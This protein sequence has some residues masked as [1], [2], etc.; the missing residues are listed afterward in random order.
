MKYIKKTL[1]LILLITLAFSYNNI[2]SS[3]VTPE[4]GTEIHGEYNH[5][6]ISYNGKKEFIEP[7]NFNDIQPDKSGDY[8]VWSREINGEGQIFRYHI[9][10]KTTLQLTHTSTNLK[11]KVDTFGR[12]VWEKWVKTGWQIYYFDGLKVN[13]LTNGQTA[14]NPD[15]EDNKIVYGLRNKNETFWSAQSYDTATQTTTELGRGEK[16]KHPKLVGNQVV[17]YLGELVKIDNNTKPTL[18]LE[19]EEIIELVIEDESKKEEQVSSTTEEV[20]ESTQ[21]NVIKEEDKPAT[22]TVEIIEAEIETLTELIQTETQESSS[23]DPLKE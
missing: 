9:P 1:K 5:V 12:V 23:S 13:Q 4:F 15:I 11:P 16:Y 18:E 6:F 14:I 19:T 8:L 22:V 17:F 7:N 21:T 3:Q 20:K 10:T 2:V